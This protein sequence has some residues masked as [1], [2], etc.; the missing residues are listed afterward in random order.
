MMTDELTLETL[1]MPTHY[2][3][4][5]GRIWD[6]SAARFVAEAPAD[7][8]VC[9]LFANSAPGDAAYLRKTLESYNKQV[10]IELLTL[11]EA[12]AAKLKEINAA[13]DDFLAVLT[14]SYPVREVLTFDQQASEAAAVLAD[15]SAPAP[16]LKPLAAARGL[17]VTELAMR[18]R[19]KSEA[20]TAIS[21]YVVGQRQKYEDILDAAETLEE[22]A[23]IVPEYT[24]PKGAAAGV[25]AGSW[26]LGAG[27]GVGRGVTG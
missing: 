7:A 25:G 14:E 27:A 17:G 18:V 13:C 15:P 19:V 12:K 11:K 9:E 26:G 20:F 22:V 3:I 2:R 6:I 5:D 21:G 4:A 10:G 8:V 23:A 16:M 24:M 1:A